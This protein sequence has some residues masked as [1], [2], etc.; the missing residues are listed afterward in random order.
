VMRGVLAGMIVPGL[1]C[2]LPVLAQ[3]KMPDD[4]VRLRDLTSNLVEDMRYAGAENFTGAVV[5]GYHAPVCW[6]RRDAAAALAAVASTLEAQGWKIVTFDCYRPKDAVA[7]FVQ[8]SKTP[9]TGITKARHYPSFDKKDLFKLGYI[10]TKSAHSTGLAV[11]AGAV[12]TDGAPIDFGTQYDFLDP[13]S[14]TENPAM[15]L[16][17]LANRRKLKAAFEAAGFENYRREWWHF[18]Y[19][20]SLKGRAV[21][22]P[23][24][25]RR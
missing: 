22:A 21:N 15:G 19:R 25:E 10:A 12:K 5:P 2:T 20:T 18:T 16:K 13:R 23:V 3:E 14:H 8:W 24:T 7:A 11:D 4:F 6:L 9:E 17:I 1:A